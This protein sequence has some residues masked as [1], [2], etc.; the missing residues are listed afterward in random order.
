MNLPPPSSAF[1]VVSALSSNRRRRGRV[2]AAGLVLVL[3]L[4]GAVAPAIFTAMEFGSSR[5]FADLELSLTSGDRVKALLSPVSEVER[6]AIDCAA[7]TLVTATVVATKVPPSKTA[8]AVRVRLL[9][10]DGN[11]LTVA[12]PGGPVAADV[13]ATRVAFRKVVAPRS[14]L[15]VVEVSAPDGTT[16]AAAGYT[17]AV[18]KKPRT[19]WRTPTLAVSP[20]QPGLLSFAASA[21]ASVRF[22]TKAPAGVMPTFGRVLEDSTPTGTD[23]TGVAPAAAAFVAPTTGTF[24]LEV[25]GTADGVVDVMATVVV[26]KTRGR[27]L[28]VTAFPDFGSGV[29]L[30]LDGTTPSDLSPEGDGL[31]G[32]RLDIPAGV[33]PSGTILLV[34]SAPTVVPSA[35]FTPAGPAISFSASAAFAK[36]A[37]VTL[38]LPFDASAANGSTSGVAVAVRDDDGNVSET[39]TGLVVDLNAGKVSFPASHFSSYQ[40]V[41]AAPAG[42]IS[43]FAGNGSS[44]TAGDG[45]PATSAGMRY[46]FGIAINASG[47][48]YISELQGHV[49]RVVDPLGVI[50]TVAGIGTGGFSGDG[51]PAT[52]ARLSF[53]AGLIVDSAGRIVFCDFLN[54]RVRRIDTSGTITTIA[55]NGTGT[56]AGDNGPATSASLFRPYMICA[57]AAGNLY[58][59]DQLNHRIRRVDTFGTITTVAGN[60]ATAFAGDGGAA[61]A[62]SI[63]SPAGVAVNAAGDIFISDEGNNRI[64]RVAASDGTISTIAGNGTYGSSGDGGPA[65]AAQ[66]NVPRALVF[67]GDGSLLFA[68][69]LNSS[70]R[71]IRNGVIDRVAGSGVQ[72]FGGDGGPALD[73]QFNEPMFVAVDGVGRLYITDNRNN[74]VR[75]VTR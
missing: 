36:G 58:I 65:A 49:I 27:K 70:V 14:G 7:G 30:T 72:A 69:V 56:F 39:T 74:R 48:V 22:K 18:S 28:D 4:A 35:G 34:G 66:V 59:A 43:T 64:R 15:V 12:G 20:S 19:K 45:G 3:A 29:A 61:T 2:R 11:A 47:A 21:G 57:D 52:A 25:I 38:T 13:T 26:P 46:P 37:T 23:F 50:S 42:I 24:Q 31:D 8:A 40:V 5:A 6:H 33:F 9:D 54:H 10:G 41:V 1:R 17:L 32:V 75:R 62:A 68:D 60:G 44:G 67:D 63:A 53:P 71:R 73:A 16:V 51:G 55:G